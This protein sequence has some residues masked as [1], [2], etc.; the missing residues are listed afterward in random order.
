[1]SDEI[2]VQV[3]KIF[4]IEVSTLCNYQYAL[5]HSSYIKDNNLPYNECYERLEFL[6]D[7][8]L[9]LAVS[10]I[11]LAKY[12]DYPEGEMSKI[13]SIVVSDAVLAKVA[14]KIGLDKLVIAGEHD[15]KQGVKRLESVIACAFEATLGAYFLDGKFNELKD[16]ICKV[17]TPYIE[18][19]DENFAK[20]NAKAILQEYTQGLTKETPVYTLV[21]SSGPAHNRTFKIEVS[22]RGEVIAS[23]TG[24]SKKDAEQHAAY[25]ACEKL[26]VLKNE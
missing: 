8:V 17:L 9:K 5:T 12:P 3:E 26:G 24:K 16:F 11:L 19:V 23:G 18:E 2:A 6:G 21:G 10:D 4:G 20:Y 22:Y 13:R 14:K 7:A 1:M 25:A 15:V